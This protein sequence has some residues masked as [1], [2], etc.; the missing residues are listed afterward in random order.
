MSC[1]T[2]EHLVAFVEGQLDD[3][4]QSAVETHVDTCD[5]CRSGLAAIVARAGSPAWTLGRYRIDGVLGAGGMG[6]VYR[7][8][9]PALA[10]AV[11]VKVVRAGGDDG[12]TARLAREAQALA[13]LNHPHVCQ[14]YDVGRDGDE[15]WI[16]MELVDGVTLR[17]WLAA[18]PPRDAVMPLLV[19]S[20]QG[21]AAAHGAGLVHRDVKPENVLVDRG[22]RAVVGDFGLARADG[23]AGATR[24][25]AVV[26]TPAY[27]APE[28]LDG[29]AADARSDQYAFAVMAHEALAG[30]RPRPRNVA[31][32]ALPPAIRAALGRALADDPARRYATLGELLDALTAAPRRRRAPMIALGVA[33]LAAIA[34]TI[35]AGAH[36]DDAPAVPAT[37]DAP[38]PS[39]KLSRS[40]SPSPSPSLSL[41]PSP[42]P[43]PS[44]PPSP[45][46]SP[47]P[48]SRPPTRPS[49]PPPAPPSDPSDPSAAPPRF[50]ATRNAPKPS[51]VTTLAEAERI[52]ASGFCSFPDGPTTPNSHPI[53]WGKVLRVADAVVLVPSGGSH[54]YPKDARLYEIAGQHRHYII[55][56]YWGVAL[57]GELGARAGDVVALCPS[58]DVAYQMPGD[59]S[60]PVTHTTVAVRVG[61]APDLHGVPLAS[62]AQL[63]ATAHDQAWSLPA[64]VLVFASSGGRLTS[65]RYMMAGWQ[66]E[67]DSATEHAL[68]PAT[69][70]WIVV[71]KP[72]WSDGV[73]VLHAAAM[74]EH[75]FPPP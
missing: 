68:D 63:V 1:P 18:R 40:P 9:D 24:T 62:S 50:G 17:A 67:I 42:S 51:H 57:H 37:S 55:D 7:G 8:W 13:R 23:D 21:L 71:D 38:P 75:V 45:S 30:A 3:G 49:P 46:P 41:S 39:P 26:G 31:S 4:A 36:S 65:G 73:T 33:A 47:S 66:L 6:I 54:A 35:T 60:G 22:G 19:A 64:R 43:S 2:A 10:R 5:S 56:G 28:Q 70:A 74:R 29:T 27:M 15:V 61:G 58:D 34:V 20:G 52:F 72:R 32:A 12:L 69:G 25:G 44:P 48:S 59:W 11:A 16:A 14:I 53:D